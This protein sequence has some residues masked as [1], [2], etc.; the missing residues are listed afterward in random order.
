MRNIAIVC[1]NIV[2]A[3]PEVVK[4]NSWDGEHLRT[5]HSAYSKPTALLSSNGRG[6]FVDKFKIPFI[7]I[8]LKSMVYTTQW[9]ETMQVSFTLTPFFLAKNS[10]EVI[11]LSEKK[12]KVKVTYEFSG[13]YIQSLFFPI[14]K[15]LIKR[16]NQQVWLEDLPLKLRRQKALEYG[17]RDFQ[18]LPTEICERKDLSLSYVTEIPVPK[19][20]GIVEDSHPFYLGK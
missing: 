5:V 19:T 13:N 20:K 16:W 6:L 4:W 11:P 2:D 1:E 17:F 8:S 15:V 9:N 10:I 12:T 7:G 18:G 3:V 14:Y